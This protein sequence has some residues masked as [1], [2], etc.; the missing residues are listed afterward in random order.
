M[1]LLHQKSFRSSL[2]F[3]LFFIASLS[4]GQVQILGWDAESN[5][6][7]YGA[8]P[9]APNTK[10]ANITTNGLLRGS[11]V[12]SSG[13][14]ASG[15]WGGSGGWGATGATSDN[16]SFYFTI[17]ANAGYKVSLSELTTDTR[18]SSSG[19]NGY[20]LYY[21][22][23]NSSFTTAGSATTTS[24]SVG[25]TSSSIALSGIAALQ[26]VAP[27][28]VIKF[29][30]NPTGATNGNYYLTDG[31]NAL[32][33]TGTV[34]SNGPVDQTI[35]FTNPASLAKTYGNT[36]FT[37]GATAS[38]NLAVTYTSSNTGVASISG[39]TVTI[40]G[41][42]TTTIT[43]NQA[44]NA[45]YNAATPVSRTLT[46]SKAVQAITFTNATKTY[47]DPDFILHGTGGASG[48]PIT[49]TSSAPEVAVI[50]GTT[51]TVLTPGSTTITASQAGNANYDAANDVVRTLSVNRK[52]IAIGGITIAD[53]TYDGTNAAIVNGTAILNTQDIVGADDVTL[54]SH[55]ATFDNA[56]VGA[57]KPVT[58][59]YTLAGL[60]ADRYLLTQPTGFNAAITTKELTIIG[61]Q[62]SNKD[63]DATTAAIITG[64]PA[65]V[66][67]VTNDDVVLDSSTA[68]A[69]F[70]TSATGTALPVIVS[71]YT[72]TG[73]AA[74]NY[75]LQ[76]P[77]G[78][79]A[80]INDLGLQNQ[81]ITFNPLAAV[82][83]GDAP[84]ALTGAAVPSGLELIYTSSNE[85]VA[86]VSGTTITVT[87][88]GTTTIT[89]TQPGNASYNPAV[90]VGQDLVVNQK[91]IT[92]ANAAI[93]DKTYTK[94]TDAVASG[95]LSGLVGNDIVV[96]TGTGTFAS[97]AAGTAIPVTTLYSI[98]GANAGNYILTQPGTLTGTILPAPVTVTTAVAQDKIYDGTA[99]TTI[100]GTLS[101]VITGDNVT[102]NGTG[103]FNAV[104]VGNAI[105]VTS[106]ATLTG[107]DSGNYTITQPTGLAA[108]ITAKAL[109]V[110]AVAQNKIYDATVA[111]TITNAT[112]TSGIIPTDDVV[113]APTINAMFTTANAGISKPVT[114]QFTLQGVHAV[115]YSIASQQYTADIMPLPLTAEVSGGAVTTKTYDATTVAALT[116]VVLNGIL[117]NDNVTVTTG[118]FA[119]ATAGTN[120]PTQLALSGTGAA[121]YTVTQPLTALEGTIQKKMLTATA[122]TKTK[123]Q[124]TANPALTVSYSGF[125]T[126]QTAANAAD[127]VVPTATT[128]ATVMSEEGA[129]P[130]IVSGGSAANYSVTLV[131]GTLLI[132][133]AATTPTT[134]LAWDFYGQS[135]PV[136]FNATTA[137]S[138]LDATLALTR[139][140]GANSSTGTNSFRTQGFQN[141]GIATTNNDY[142]QF[143]ISSSPDYQLSLSTINAM[144]NGT[145]SY[146]A[147]P[148]VSH[149]LA[150]SLN[151]T[152]FTLINSP[153]ITI[154][155]SS[156]TFTPSI[157]INISNIPALQNI[158][159]NTTVTFRYYAS[160]QTSSG[161]WGFYSP[162]PGSFGLAVDGAVIANPSAPLISSALAANSV[163]GDSDA[164]QITATGSP[165]ITITATNLPAGATIDNT[166]LITFDGTTP[167]GSYNIPMTATSYFGT[168][169]KTLVYTVLK[170]NQVITFNP[171]T[172][173][174]KHP[175]D[176]P[177][178]LSATSNSGLPLSW[179]SSD[180]TVATIAADGTVTIIGI[181]TATLTASNAGNGQ[182]N[183]ISDGRTLTVLATPVLSVVPNAITLNA[184]EGHG[185]S[186][187][188]SLT[189]VSGANLLPASGAV[190]FS[191]TDGFELSMGNNLYNNSGALAYTGGTINEANPTISVRFA[192]GHTVGTYTGV[193]TLT[194]GTTTTTIP[195]TAIVA[196]A[197]SIATTTGN[198][199]PYC[200]AAE[201]TITVTYTTTGVF[202]AG[203][204]Y[205]QLSDA[206]GIFPNDFTT[207]ISPASSTNSIT[208]TLP[209]GLVAGNYDVRV[210]HYSTALVFTASTNTNGTAI[211][212]NA[213]PTVSGV[214]TV[215]ACTGSDAQI[216][217]SG[218]LTNTAFTV[219]YTVNGGTPQ[220]LSGM[221]SDATGTA[222]F[223][224]PVTAT[225]NG[226]TV[227]VTSL[228]TTATG[229]ET[230]FT[231]NNSTILIVTPAPTAI[232]L[233]FCQQATVAEL[234]A[235]GTQLQWYTALTGG[236]AL[237]ST[238]SLATGNYY[239][240]QTINGCE[241]IR[242]EVAVT[243]NTPA[244]PTAIA[245]AFC[246]QATVAELTATGTQLQWYTALTGGIAL[247]STTPLASGNYYV[248][249]TINGCE[250][251]RTEVAVTINTPAAPTAIALAFCQQA[252]VAE[253]TATGTQLQWYTALTGGTALEN[254]T[255]L[256]SGNYYVS[257]TINGCESTRTE[258]A[259]TIGNVVVPQGEANQEYLEGAILTDLI[260]NGTNL[261]WYT[262]AAL[263]T[264]I[265]PT[266]PL[267]D[268]TT[269]YVVASLGECR[270]EALM[271]TVTALLKNPSFEM[272]GL[273]Y[274]P[275]PVKQVLTISNTESIATIVV[276]D[277][278]GRKVMALQ[279]NAIQTQISLSGLPS[280]TYLLEV[281]SGNVSK[282]VK[283]IKQ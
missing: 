252:T 181:G 272:S 8:S 224:L 25:G 118:I 265:E 146:A 34:A 46:V 172:I 98:S 103:L 17:T 281:T 178:I 200:S 111:A 194:V 196:V 137:N 56:N 94:N 16:N 154:G 91:T 108:A 83:Y 132:G 179:T 191:I 130:I 75:T 145:A 105:A 183:A 19:P 76:Q 6:G 232:A 165:V 235:T 65:L 205:V 11:G 113:L 162:S 161:G 234:T 147:A 148:G 173:P 192:A 222:T 156:P 89:A 278:T 230:T 231:T 64:T 164:Y 250:S 157:S 246:Q 256:A 129:Y 199:G 218:L 190:S 171:D 273:K 180:T 266:T 86:T 155:N 226:S 101:G 52:P 95:V 47:G 85:N 184:T 92:V 29:R 102:L 177:F 99:S 263:T 30:I 207:I 53:K 27:G 50:T 215:A 23:G 127:F 125:V 267:T 244:A 43:A 60:Q 44:G 213:Q 143:A 88:V 206:A 93:T 116:G 42:G 26:N 1:K 276:Y 63:Y 167:A 212:I 223:A 261:I 48:E 96:L 135:S 55:T 166:G 279:P 2:T 120:I 134:I 104:A 259:V 151:G 12:S 35:T 37:L 117:N 217:L 243:I 268:G 229:C 260:V 80:D 141:N 87:G 158:P 239:V 15:G 115:N 182:F 169:T 238:A 152:T 119:T 163:I 40:T 5:G 24:T 33:V 82:T 109:T 253:L 255:P 225:D 124:G 241:S 283:V 4:W 38:S 51:V 251:T 22:V 79:T 193:L 274:Y 58:V 280:G 106:T 74:A 269:Y 142:F 208:A 39:N 18:R 186:L 247:E 70:S 7:G 21:A 3:L 20:T 123:N 227:A 28:T 62:I 210:I 160:G 41:A 107:P 203:D 133:A 185:A 31:T 10:N 131:N 197:P 214:T 220:Q 97:A 219:H 9:W 270:S 258:V 187:P 221:L 81:T 204:F 57:N 100:T 13:T 45:S 159:A 78:L 245:L 67:V 140:S 59:A 136:G 122:D 242:T 71:G 66:G 188:V 110:N 14:P 138:H 237:E 209:A 189:D 236:T 216:T 61:I 149:Q 121:N 174:V 73:T 68:T 139:G 36:P 69:V 249:Q 170:Q 72:L 128:S 112:I 271:I 262:D 202:D 114:A 77:Q 240:S 32:N 195:L 90:A 248:S 233:A 211:V 254:T 201:N 54:G 264:E 153:V 257:Q 168:D 282:R 275:N 175:G 150:Y 176:T 277:L 49:Y 144:F 126:G 228:I 84:F 198:Y